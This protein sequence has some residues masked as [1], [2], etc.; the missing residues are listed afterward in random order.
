MIA[1]LVTAAALSVNPDLDKA[2]RLVGDL[3]YAEA[4]TALDAALRRSGNDRET[5]IRIYELQG[6]VFGTLNQTAKAAR[7]FQQMLSLDPD[8]KLTGDNPP[9]VTTPFYEARGKSSDAGRLEAKA[10]APATAGG[11]VAQLA[12]EITNDPMRMVK[13]V[14]FHVKAD[15]KSWTVSQADVVGKNASVSTDGALVKWW[16][17]V[18]GDREAVLLDLGSADSPKQEGSAPVA[19]P[20][21]KPVPKEEP[22]A[23]PP[24][25]AVEVATAPPPAEGTSGLRL[26][27]YGLIAAGAVGLAVGAVFGVCSF[28][29]RNLIDNATTDHGVVTSISQARAF[30]LDTQVH[31]QATVANT[32]LAV[33][34]GL[35]A[36]GVVLFVVS[37]SPSA[38]VALVPAGNGL[39]LSGSW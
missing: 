19:Q 20:E 34:G 25:A 12:V 36:I 6:L 26:G 2:A 9:R 35:A 17:E 39:L 24:P 27:A 7:A 10:L 15:D 37:P 3:Q 18:L 5:L 11:R 21:I 38:S 28:Y 1:A 16:A 29:N 32:L 22:V 23:P 4:Q 33:G 31:L 14:R 8:K 30:A 13:R